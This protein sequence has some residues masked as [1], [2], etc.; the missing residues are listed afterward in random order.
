MEVPRKDMTA[1]DDVTRRLDEDPVLLS[2]GK[3]SGNDQAHTAEPEERRADGS[4]P[5]WALAEVKPDCI[6]DQERAYDI[7]VEVLEPSE[8]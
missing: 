4:S 2:P 8:R 6:G 5:G 1:T 3:D 7:E